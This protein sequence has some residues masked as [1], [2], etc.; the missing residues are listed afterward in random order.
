MSKSPPFVIY[1]L[2]V[3][4]PKLLGKLSFS[5]VALWAWK[6]EGS[7][8]CGRPNQACLDNLPSSPGKTSADGAPRQFRLSAGAAGDPSKFAWPTQ[9]LLPPSPS[10]GRPG[11]P[12]PHLPLLSSGPALG[13]RG[14][15]RACLANQAAPTSPSVPG[16][17]RMPGAR[18]WYPENQAPTVTR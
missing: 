9:L 15:K 1:F 5:F 6:N 12:V 17:T 13:C 7:W 10:L 18:N 16:T 2:P 14:L 8:G 11:R 3:Y 4:P